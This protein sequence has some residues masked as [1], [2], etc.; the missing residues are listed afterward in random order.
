MKEDLTFA[1]KLLLI[2][3]SFIIVA[4]VYLGVKYLFPITAPFIIAYL[5][6]LG[7]ERPVGWLAG[8][9]RGRKGLAA[10]L[11]VAVLIILLVSGI[12]YVLWLGVKELKAFLANYDYYVIYVQQEAAGICHNIDG[13]LGITDGSSFRFLCDMAGKMSRAATD[14]MDTQM[15]GKVVSVSLPV[16]V[17]TIKIAGSVIIGVMSV[18]YLSGSLED[19]RN[20]CRKSVFRREIK[21]VSDSLG[22]LIQVYFKVQLIII[23]VN[24]VICVL[25]L[26]IIGNPY[27]LLI[28]VLIGIFD[29][30]PIFGAGTILLPWAVFELISGNFLSAAVLVTLYLVTYFVREILE[31]KCMG[32]RLGIAPFTMLMVIF[33][34]LMV[35]GIM[36][37][38][39]G[40][41]SYCIIKALILY[42]KTIVERGKLE[43][44]MENID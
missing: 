31:S 7:I 21:L 42:L 44:H 28:G 10:A 1:R 12:G 8:K 25:G 34:G 37:F 3:G 33:V 29:A 15:V 20:W 26:M 11:I 40:P 2:V 30:L 5:V 18:I 23:V 22:R 19:I 24:A 9:L 6:A 41:V 35:Y 32:K 38:I 14:G 17:N 4:S 27:A 16:A 43:G 13:W 39:L 36:G